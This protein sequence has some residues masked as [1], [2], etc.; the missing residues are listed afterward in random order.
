VDESYFWVALEFRICR[1]FAG[2][3]ERNMQYRWCDGLIPAQFLLDDSTQLGFRS[4][5][6]RS[7]LGLLRSSRNQQASA[8]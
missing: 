1:E 8:L 7:L 5:P 3:P 4:C 6:R 2:M